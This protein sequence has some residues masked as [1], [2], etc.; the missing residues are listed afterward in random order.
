VREG[1]RGAGAD[2]EPHQA[3]TRVYGNGLRAASPFGASWRST[4]LRGDS[5]PV[6]GF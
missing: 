4:A 1:E 3:L 6:Q 2:T 5:R